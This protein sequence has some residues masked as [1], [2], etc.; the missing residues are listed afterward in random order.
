MLAKNEGI[1]VKF[2]EAS[3]ENVNQLGK[4]DIVICI[5]VAAT[6]VEN[7]LGAIRAKKPPM[8]PQF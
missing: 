1:D 2:S 3:I 6:E 7:I 8:K 5:A 4:F